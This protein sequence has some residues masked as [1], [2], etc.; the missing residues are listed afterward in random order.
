[1]MKC[2]QILQRWKNIWS[3]EWKS[4]VTLNY[5]LIT[6]REFSTSMLKARIHFRVHFRLSFQISFRRSIRCDF[7]FESFGK[8]SMMLHYESFVQA[9][10]EHLPTLR[11]QM[12]KPSRN[13][14]DRPTK[15]FS[16]V[17]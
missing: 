7:R 17:S 9:F 15:C 10:G 5:F 2:L 13:P 8:D 16:E 14:V 3:V 12:E 4:V 1:M 11:E 6:E